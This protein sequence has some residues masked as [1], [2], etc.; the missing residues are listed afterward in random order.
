MKY[1]VTTLALMLILATSAYAGNRASQSA[2]EVVTGQR[3]GMGQSAFNNV[4]GDTSGQTH[5]R[6]RSTVRP[7]VRP[8]VP[9]QPCPPRAYWVNGHYQWT[10]Q[11]VWI[12]DA[13]AERWV[14]PIF[15]YKLVRGQ[16][17]KYVVQAGFYERYVIPGHYELRQVQIWVPG[18]WCYY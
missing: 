17:V 11:Q 10:Q 7:Y 2:S 5:T 18:Y 4:F 16:V 6:S 9:Q 8:N 3:P 14:P 12:P 15:D 1:V 13:W